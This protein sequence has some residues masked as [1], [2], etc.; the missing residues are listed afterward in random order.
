MPDKQPTKDQIKEW[1]AQYGELFEL[2]VDG[3]T[4][5]VGKPNRQVAGLAMAKSR[6]NPLSMVEVVLENCMVWG[7]RSILEDAGALIG[8]QA[9]IDDIFQTATVSLKK[10]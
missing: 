4:I 8:L 1:K 10:L 6:S 7:D 9:H 3:R 5:I 2:D